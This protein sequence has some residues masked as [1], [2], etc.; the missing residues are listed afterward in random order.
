MLGCQRPDVQGVDGKKDAQVLVGQE[1][2]LAAHGREIAL[3]PER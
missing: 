2:Y 3:V 1:Q